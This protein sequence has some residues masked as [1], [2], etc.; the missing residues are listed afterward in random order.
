VIASYYGLLAVMG[1]STRALIIESIVAGVFMLF[2]VLG[3]KGKY[4]LVIAA[5]IGHGRL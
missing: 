4:W 5:L 3:F 1:A 2:A